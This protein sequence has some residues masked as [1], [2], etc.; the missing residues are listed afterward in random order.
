MTS[1]ANSNAGEIFYAL[2][3]DPAGQ[4]SCAHTATEALFNVSGTFV[5]E[6]QH[7][8]SFFHHVVARGGEPEEPWLNEGLSHIAEELASR[9]F[10]DEVV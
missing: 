6:M 1:A 10:E 9:V 8:I 2:V 3:P 7:M 5:H 4:Y